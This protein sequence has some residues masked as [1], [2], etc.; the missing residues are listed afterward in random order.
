MK[1]DLY[2]KITA[3]GTLGAAIATLAAVIVASYAIYS[4][5]EQTQHVLTEEF[6]GA[7]FTQG[8][9]LIIKYNERFSGEFL[10]KRKKAALA[11][12]HGERDNEQ[13]YDILD[14]FE[15]IGLL[16]RRGAIDEEMV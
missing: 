7:R 6:N 13:V 5:N 9:D 4:Q 2:G 10:P 3:W 8:V 15:E 14:F 16:V 12:L 11:L 1:S